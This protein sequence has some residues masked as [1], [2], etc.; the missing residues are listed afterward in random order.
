MD[1]NIRVAILA[2]VGNVHSRMRYC[3]TIVATFFELLSDCLGA[4]TILLWSDSDTV[5]NA[6]IRLQLTEKR[7]ITLVAKTGGQAFRIFLACETPK[8]YCPHARG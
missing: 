1:P 8:L 2:G 7:R 6:G 4:V 5:Q 3:P